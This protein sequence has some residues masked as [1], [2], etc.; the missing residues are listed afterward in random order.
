MSPL[1]ISRFPLPPNLQA[2]RF[3]ATKRTLG[4]GAAAAVAGGGVT[5]VVGLAGAGR[6]AAGAAAAGVAAGLGHTASCWASSA[7]TDQ[8]CGTGRGGGGMHSVGG[9][10]GNENETKKNEA[11]VRMNM[12]SC[13]KK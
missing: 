7:C 2:A 5:A 4:A 13:K 1:R 6:A 3:H 9:I 8:N 11:N 10:W 12:I